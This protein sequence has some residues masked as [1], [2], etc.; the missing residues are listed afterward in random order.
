M[1]IVLLKVVLVLNIDR[2]LTTL[3]LLLLISFVVSVVV[4]VNMDLCTC[5]HRVIKSVG[6]AYFAVNNDNK[7]NIAPVFIHS[8][9]AATRPLSIERAL[10]TDLVIVGGFY[11]SMK[12]RRSW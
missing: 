4:A 6:A 7:L 3:L 12:A 9:I 1:M 2:R 5:C 11:K 8:K 10:K